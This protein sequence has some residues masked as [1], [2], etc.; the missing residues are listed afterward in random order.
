MTSNRIVIEKKR[1]ELIILKYSISKSSE[2]GD[3]LLKY[4]NYCN[5]SAMHGRHAVCSTILENVYISPLQNYCTSLFDDFVNQSAK[6]SLYI[7]LYSMK[8]E[9]KIHINFFYYLLKDLI[10]FMQINQLMG[11]STHLNG[12][13]RF[14]ST[15]RVLHRCCSPQSFAAGPEWRGLDGLRVPGRTEEYC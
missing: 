4:R 1:N 14:F 7:P 11:K 13:V 9:K 2:I 15:D 3:R 10:Y 8:K 12:I 6:M 5:M